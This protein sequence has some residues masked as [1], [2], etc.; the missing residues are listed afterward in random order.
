[1]VKQHFVLP[2]I[3]IVAATAIGPQPRFMGIIIDMAAD[4]LAWRQFHMGWFLVTCLAQYRLMCAFEREAGHRI[5][6]ELSDLPVLA[7]VTFGAIGA[8]S[9]FMRIF[10]LVAADA[11]HRWFLDG[12]VRAVAA[13]TSRSGMRPDQFES[14]IL[15][16]IEIDRFPR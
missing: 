9:A 3:D 15:I 13:C 14:G 7:V 11:C 5:V 12:I 16:V 2:A 8:V 10:L 1:M 4:A 6:I